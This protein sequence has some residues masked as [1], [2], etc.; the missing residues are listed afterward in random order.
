MVLKGDEPGL[1]GLEPAV[2]G[3]RFTEAG[4][5]KVLVGINKRHGPVFMAARLRSQVEVR[6]W[7]D[8]KEVPVS[9]APYEARVS[10]ND[11]ERGVHEIEIEAAPGT[12]IY[13]LHFEIAPDVKP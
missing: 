8:G 4:R 11:L 3:A 9:W 10:F 5:A 6:V 13:E 1:V 7:F 12:I 2:G